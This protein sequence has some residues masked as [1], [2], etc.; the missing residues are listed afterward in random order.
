M[1]QHQSRGNPAR[2]SQESVRGNAFLTLT[3][4]D[5]L[6]LEWKKV[7]FFFFLQDSDPFNRCTPLRTTKRGFI[8]YPILLIIPKKNMKC[9]VDLNCAKSPF[10]FPKKIPGTSRAPLRCVSDVVRTL[11]KRSLRVVQ[12]ATP[13]T[14]WKCTYKGVLLGLRRRVRRPAGAP[15][16]SILGSSI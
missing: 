1:K 10:F 6:L 3:C 11:L 13:T 8:R 15:P 4:R 7:G 9:R 14:A 2:F 16:R 5:V 12:S